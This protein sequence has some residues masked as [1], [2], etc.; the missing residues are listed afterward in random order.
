MGTFEV[1]W[2]S[3]ERKKSRNSG[4]KVETSNSGLEGR[5]DGINGSLKLRS[6]WV[7]SLMWKAQEMPIKKYLNAEY[8]E[9]E[10]KYS[11]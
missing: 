6:S 2:K 5:G 4:V 11:Y 7:I 1:R 8:I 3:V 9:K 10:T